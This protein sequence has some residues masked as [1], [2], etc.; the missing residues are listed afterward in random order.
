MKTDFVKELNLVIN[1]YSVKPK[2]IKDGVS[3]K[4]SAIC[5][6]N[7]MGFVLTAD[8]NKKLEALIKST[9][10]LHCAMISVEN[11]EK[12]MFYKRNSV[13]KSIKPTCNILV[14]TL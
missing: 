12:A 4:I 1:N 6:N 5:D 7:D 11:V 14:P 10:D 13:D 2:T 3:G 9:V 8:N